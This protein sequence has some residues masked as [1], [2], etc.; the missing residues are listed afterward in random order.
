[1]LMLMLLLTAYVFFIEEVCKPRLDTADEAEPCGFRFI[2]RLILIWSSD[3]PNPCIGVLEIANSF[4]LKYI[5]PDPI[6]VSQ[7]R[8]RNFFS[9]R[10]CSPPPS[11]QQLAILIAF[12]AHILQGTS[13]PA[14]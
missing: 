2:S 13:S 3:V 12:D 1:M 7:L 10:P 14:Q 6:Q 5:P 9:R 11:G 8:P 4:N